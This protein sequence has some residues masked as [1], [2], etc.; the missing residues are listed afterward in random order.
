MTSLECNRAPMSAL[1]REIELSWRR[2]Q[3][4]GVQPEFTGFA[5]LSV[6]E[7]DPRSR[8]LDAAAPVLDQ[9]AATLTGTAY[10]LLL[11]DRDCRLVYHWFDNPRVETALETLGIRDGANLAEDSIG[12]NAL[13]TALETR[14]GIIINGSEHYIERFKGLTCYGHPILHPVTRRLAGVLDITSTNSH[15]DPL[16]APFLQ[17]AVNDIEHRLLD[18]AKA[19]ERAL[20]AAFQTISRQRRAVAAVGDDIVLT[21]NSA[22]DLLGPSDYAL[23]HMLAEQAPARPH[24]TDVRLASGAAV[25]LH[26]AQVTGAET[27]MLFH[28]EPIADFDVTVAARP[29]V[30]RLADHAPTT[31]GPVLVVGDHGTGRST[32]AR[33]LARPE[34]VEFHQCA[35]IATCGEQTWVRRLQERLARPAGAVCLDGVDALPER[36]VDQLIGAIKSKPRPKIILSSL[37]LRDAHGAHAALAAL[38]AERVEIPPLRD[39]IA[40]LPAITK[41]LLRELDP[42]ADVRLLP[43]VI[44]LLAAQPWPGN[45]HELKAVLAHILQHRHQGDVTVRDLPDRYRVASRARSLSGR[46]RA[47]RDVIIESLRRYN[48]NKQK[49]AHELGISRTTLYA[50]LK[51][52]RITDGQPPVPRSGSR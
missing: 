17:R 19:S 9:I 1:R 16:L 50:R 44:E 25:R 22:V 23:L 2:S 11:V 13:G 26:I 45:L 24:S 47:E 36:V 32:A 3:L 12:T 5:D 52:L 38:C 33:R 51:A 28:F 20:L 41:D 27:G 40:E 7:F 10:S 49:T 29:V 6:T 30:T 37:P 15:A 21:N 39:R 46:E 35:D 34:E 42:A 8:L 18:Q 14:R 48:G 31:A 43:S 4:S